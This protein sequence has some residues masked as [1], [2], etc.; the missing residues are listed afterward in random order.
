MPL[1]FAERLE[2]LGG[3]IQRVVACEED[4]GP[5]AR[6]AEIDFDL[7]AGGFDE[8]IGSRFGQVGLEVQRD[9]V[10]IVERRVELKLFRLVDAQPLANVGETVLPAGGERCAGEHDRFGPLE[11]GLAEDLIDAERGGV[12]G[13]P[14]FA[15]L[16]RLQPV[17]VLRELLRQPPLSS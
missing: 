17:D 14:R 1:L 6:L 2:D 12:Q 5:A 9:F 13:G 8:R 10:G 15:A 11:E 4:E 16:G 7:L 3:P